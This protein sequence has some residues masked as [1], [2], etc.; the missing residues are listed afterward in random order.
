MLL[1]QK[2]P[3]EAPRIVVPDFGIPIRDSGYDASEAGECALMNP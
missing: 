3:L 1:T 2:P